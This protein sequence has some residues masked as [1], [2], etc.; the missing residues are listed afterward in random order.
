[1][2]E[3][4]NKKIFF[5]AVFILMYIFIQIG[6]VI[7]S[8]DKLPNAVGKVGLEFFYRLNGHSL[9]LPFYILLGF[10]INNIIDTNYHKNKYTTFQNFIVERTKYKNRL[11]QEITNV[12]VVS[13]F[14]RLA[15]HIF[16]FIIINFSCC[17]IRL[18]FT[19]DPSY[20]PDSFF[21]FSNN[22]VISFFIYIIYSCIGFSILSLFLYSLIP[23]IKN[24]Y[25]YKISGILVSV[26]G[27]M[28]PALIGNIYI[29]KVGKL[30]LIGNIITNIFNSG[31]LLSPG[32][33]SFTGV[34][35][36]FDKHAMYFLACF[37]YLALTAILLL[38]RYKRERKNG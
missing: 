36:I 27:V 15:I 7:M 23:F 4:S 31:G 29:S 12:L 32:I 20:Y 19:G 35:T 24:L 9:Y 30:D 22:S 1:M 13:F 10:L 37:G 34:I 21:A 3:L 26:L 17:K 38:Y 8:F 28:I 6:Y 16:T 11:K 14:V 5:I 25:V 18:N 33:E 2:K